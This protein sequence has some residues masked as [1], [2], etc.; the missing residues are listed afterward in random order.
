MARRVRYRGLLVV[1][2]L[3]LAVLGGKAGALADDGGFA[4][5]VHPDNPIAAVDREL[6]RDAYLRKASQWRN[7]GAIHVVDLSPR[8]QAR[9][10]FARDVLK[11]TPAQLKR[12]WNQQIFTGKGIPPRELD[13]TAAVIAYVLSDRG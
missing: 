7:G 13:S 11:K 9:D 5:V 4:I 2:A 1:G 8:F 10:R 6:L 3:W 12:Y